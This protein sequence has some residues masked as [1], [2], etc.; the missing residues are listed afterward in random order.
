MAICSSS[1][2]DELDDSTGGWAKLLANSSKC[3]RE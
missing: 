1:E 3:V 2:D